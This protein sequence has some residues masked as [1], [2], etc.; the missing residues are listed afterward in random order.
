VRSPGPEVRVHGLR[1]RGHEELRPPG[2]LVPLI[3]PYERIV[4]RVSG[5]DA[6]IGDAARGLP[7]GA[8]LPEA[9]AVRLRR[10]GVPIAWGEPEPLETDGDD[11]A[12]RERGR[13]SMAILRSDPS[14]VCEMQAGGWFNASARGR[15]V[16]RVLMRLPGLG[17]LARRAGGRGARWAADAAFW[18]GVAEEASEREWRRLTSS[19]VAL[20]Y[21]RLAGEGRPGQ[22]ELDLPPEQFRRQLRLLRL[23]RFRALTE[24][25]ILDFHSDSE[26]VLPQRAYALTVDDGFADCVEP[27]AAAAAHA[28]QLFVPTGAVGGRAR[29]A[30]DEPVAGWEQLTWLE[31]AGVRMGSHASTHRRLPE[32]GAAGAGEELNE[33]RGQ[34]ETRLEQP[35]ASVAYP[36]GAH[37]ADVRGAAQAAGHPAAWTTVV[38]RNGAGTDPYCLRRVGVKARDTRLS[39]MW[40]VVTGELPP[41]RWELRRRR[42]AGV[43]TP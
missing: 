9:V 11:A 6:L 42:R 27:L 29:W 14:L 37:D 35:L 16:R 2:S 15:L 41:R 33:A 13:S 4:A 8:A 43:R 31:R 24:Q 19:Y 5:P 30:G 17:A 39:F 3:G 12:A 7:P 10:R 26:G 38:G 40:K 25:E 18:R 1:A 23:L 32:L 21:H 36:H 34:L 20:L 28:P 22:E